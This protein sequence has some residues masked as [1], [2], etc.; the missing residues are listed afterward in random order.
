MLTRMIQ[1]ALVKAGYVNLNMYA[2]GSELWEALQQWRDAPD[3]P[4]HVALVITD[5]EMPQMDGHRL[6]K[7]IKSDAFFQTIPVVIFSSLI[8]EEMRRKGKEVGADEQLSK[9]EIGHLI[10]IVDHLLERS[11]SRREQEEHK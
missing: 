10:G 9:P 2:N 3:L 1:E 7:L 6:T 8:T 11:Q 5:L 4:E